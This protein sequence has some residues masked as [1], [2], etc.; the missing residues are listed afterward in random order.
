MLGWLTSN[1]LLWKE[2]EGTV[3]TSG[4]CITP[5]LGIEWSFFFD[6]VSHIN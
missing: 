1:F 3:V 5:T 2:S 6:R 4:E